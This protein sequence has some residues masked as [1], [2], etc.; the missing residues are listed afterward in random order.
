MTGYFE[1]SKSIWLIST[2]GTWWSSLAS[3]GYSPLHSLPLLT[4]QLPP[5]PLDYSP[6]FKTT[7]FGGRV[8]STLF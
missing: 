2:V 6:L 5:Y 1:P 3:S 8:T 7:Y 4:T